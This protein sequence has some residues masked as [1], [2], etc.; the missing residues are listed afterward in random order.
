MIEDVQTADEILEMAVSQY[1]NLWIQKTKSESS[2]SSDS[3]LGIEYKDVD[4]MNIESQIQNRECKTVAASE[5]TTLIYDFD[6][7]GNA[8]IKSFEDVSKNGFDFIF[9]RA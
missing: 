4:E 1:D 6:L 7:E 9:G 2:L 8:V 5:P 3:A